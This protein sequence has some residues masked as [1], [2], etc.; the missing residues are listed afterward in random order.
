MSGFNVLSF[1]SA[2]QAITGNAA[3]Y[4]IASIT[5]KENKQLVFDTNHSTAA[6][7]AI[8]CLKTGATATTLTL[9]NNASMIFRNNSSATK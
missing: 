3:I 9:E 6:G 8:H 5:I 1:I 4:G 7:G 2:P